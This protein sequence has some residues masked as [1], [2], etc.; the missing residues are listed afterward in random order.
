MNPVTAPKTDCRTNLDL[1]TLPGFVPSLFPLAN[2]APVP[3]ASRDALNHPAVMAF[4]EAYYEINVRWME[5][6]AV[7][8]RPD[9]PDVARQE[10]AALQAVEAALRQRDELEDRY[11]PYGIIAEPTID[12]GFTIDVRFSFGNVDAQGRMRSELYTLSTSFPLPLPPG[13][14]LED[15]RFT[16]DGPGLHDD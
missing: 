10:R 4:L 6:R 7:R 2:G 15:L 9:A 5:L 16:I 11:A 3:A 13:V 8:S 14:K 12:N 1:R